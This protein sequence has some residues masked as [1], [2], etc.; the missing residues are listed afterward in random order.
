MHHALPVGQLAGR[1]ADAVLL[2]NDSKRVLQFH[3]FL[4]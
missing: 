4:L 3:V 1:R 2:I